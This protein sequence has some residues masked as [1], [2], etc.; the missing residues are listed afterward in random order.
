MIYV[1]STTKNDN[2]NEIDYHVFYYDNILYVHRINN[3][4]YYSLPYNHKNPS[5]RAWVYCQKFDYVS[6]KKLNIAN[7]K[8][9]GDIMDEIIFNNI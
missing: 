8:K 2:D 7:G 5:F 9:I 3:N 6:P 1:F 4:K